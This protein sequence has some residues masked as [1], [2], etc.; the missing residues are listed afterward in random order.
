MS[1]AP[2]QQ[3]D[4]PKHASHVDAQPEPQAADTGHPNAADKP[5]H[6][7]EM[8][9]PGIEEEAKR[10]KAGKPLKIG[11]ATPAGQNEVK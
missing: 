10:A 11:A 2:K 8:H 9:K 6:E 4:P 5:F 3:P 1:T 7:R